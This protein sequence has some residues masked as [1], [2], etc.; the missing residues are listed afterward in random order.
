MLDGLTMVQIK[1]LP[2]LRPTAV[3]IDTQAPVIAETTG[4]TLRNYV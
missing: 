1:P 2:F 3:A 4:S